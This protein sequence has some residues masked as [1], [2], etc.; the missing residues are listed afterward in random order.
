MNHGVQIGREVW[1]LILT[2]R[3]AR[4]ILLATDGAGWTLPEVEVRPGQR[5]ADQVT[6]GVR[7]AWGIE[8]CCLF[9][10]ALAA[11]AVPASSL[12]YF[13]LESTQQNE[14][15]PKDTGW[16]PSAVAVRESTLS[17]HDR[18]AVR[19]AFEELEGYVAKHRRGPFGRPG[20][21]RELFGWVGEQVVPLG[22]RPT[23]AF[24][25][26]NAS[27]TFSL[28]RIETTG[29]AVW[30]KATGAPNAHELPITVTLARH[31]PDYV[32]ALLGIHSPWNGWLSREAEGP[33]LDDTSEA[34]A[35]TRTA[36]ALAD[37]QIT[38]LG[39][40][41]DLLDSGCKEARL[42]K[43]IEHID[44]FLARMAEL[45]TA[46][47]QQ[48]PF[49]LG[50]QEVRFVGEALKEACS[51]LRDL[52]LPDTLG[53]LDF[54][55]ENIVISPERCV[56]LDWAEGCVAHPFVTFEYLREHAG[57]RFPEGGGV[58]E[59]I[60]A[61]YLRPWQ[62]FFSPD[63]LARGLSV[64]PL[65]AVYVYAVGSGRW[66]S[67]EVFQ[68]PKLAGYFRS[69]TRRMHQKAARIRQGSQ[70]CPS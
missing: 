58:Q 36:K 41:A 9:V 17:A 12:K 26:F 11:G 31:F 18:I 25:Q 8:T 67:P 64:S 14:N 30:F 28:I 2:R 34:S 15:A 68:T 70:L 60:T 39:K 29:P 5:L 23:G 22:L 20:W 54:N 38:A 32:P 50:D 4:E 47:E 3:A 61:A 46:Q 24:Q 55:P 53:H 49:A 40:N 21:V 69:L 37:L 52:G 19:S 63:E 42:P 65:V 43:L 62:A 16:F 10:P 6:G 44:P 35:W 59:D 13:V 66:R 33:T 51:T 57:R 48:P 56:F 27:P 7:Q 1:R 45:M